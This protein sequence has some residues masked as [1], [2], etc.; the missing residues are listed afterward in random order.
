VGL[1]S[2]EQGFPPQRFT[3]VF[4]RAKRHGLHRVAHAGEE[5]TAEYVRGAIESL[6]VERIDHGNNALSDQLLVQQ[7]VTTGMPLTLCSLSNLRL[8]VI[9]SLTDHPLRRMFDLGLRVTVNSDDPAYF[10][11]YINANFPAV[12][13]ALNL[14]VEQMARNSFTAA[15]ASASDKQTWLSEIDAY[16]QTSNSTTY[17]PSKIAD[18]RITRCTIMAI[19]AGEYELAAIL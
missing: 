16:V 1:Y 4:E 9:A 14:S 3:D 11:G 2:S 6:Q 7:L 17:Q 15:F 10:G 13:D 5:G 12:T 8:K 19:Y 18:R